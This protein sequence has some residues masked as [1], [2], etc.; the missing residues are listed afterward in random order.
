MILPLAPSFSLSE[1]FEQPLVPL[2]PTEPFFSFPSPFL[3]WTFFI[4]PYTSRS[5]VSALDLSVDKSFPRAFSFPYLDSFS[6]PEIRVPWEFFLLT[7][8]LTQSD[9][10]ADFS[11]EVSI[12]SLRSTE[13]PSLARRIE[14]LET[15]SP[16][17][18]VVSPNSF[19]MAEW[20][21]PNGDALGGADA[22]G[23]GQFD[24]FADAGAGG[25]GDDR[26]CYTCGQTGYDHGIHSMT[27]LD[28]FFAS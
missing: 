11:S 28:L 22:F 18:L 20:T 16:T 24:D 14:S 27:P 1:S 6:Y 9:E 7:V 4:D 3:A 23:A 26:A 15:T 12:S 2:S 10:E 21:A 5:S 25:A 13:A 17:T 8:P 19:A